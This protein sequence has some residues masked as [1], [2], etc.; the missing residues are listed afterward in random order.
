MGGS[1][2]G[3]TTAPAQSTKDIST[4]CSPALSEKGT[5][6][7]FHWNTETSQ[8]PR[9]PTL[10]LH[11]AV[12]CAATSHEEERRI[13]RQTNSCCI[14]YISH[15]GLPASGLVAL[16][17][18]QPFSHSIQYLTNFAFPFRAI[19]P[20]FLTAVSRCIIITCL[21]SI[22]PLSSTLQLEDVDLVA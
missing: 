10:D 12:S 14:R 5:L 15:R 9:S 7:F 18:R 20:S 22:L 2:K 3:V 17:K 19:L 8:I 13:I 6:R 4:G 16:C 21:S 11:G 1:N